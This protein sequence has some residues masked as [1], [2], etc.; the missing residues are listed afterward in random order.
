MLRLNIRQTLPQIG[1]RTRLS[2]L[3]AHMVQPEAHS[4]YQAPRSHQ[5]M[6]QA[7][8]EID[9]YPSRKSYGA[10]TNADFVAE[11]AQRAFSDVQSATSKHTN[12]AWSFIDNAAKK[13]HDEVVSQA[14][15]EISAEISKQRYIEAQAIP[16]P[17]VR[18]VPAELTGDI[19]P[20]YYRWNVDVQ[21]TAE[22]NFN[23]GSVEI[24]MQ[25]EADIRQWVT[26]DKY[27]IYA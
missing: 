3:S 9:S 6:K 5:S 27:D 12:D 2:T 21:P 17:T 1:I 15:G 13:G 7:T 11:R 22:V 4:E 23:R 26:E 24:Y 8:V 10:R 25:Q 18:G 14:K 19:D 20:G 16:N